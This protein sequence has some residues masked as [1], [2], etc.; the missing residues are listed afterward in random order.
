MALTL[1]TEPQ[2]EPV[3]LEEAKQQVLQ[4]LTVDDS[5]LGTILIP[6]AR[7][8]AELATGRALLTQTWDLVLDGFPCDSHIEI[9]K[10]PLQ[11]VTHLKYRDNV[12]TLQTWATSNYVVEAP[13]GPRCRRGRLSLAYGI[14]WPATYG[15]AGDVTVRFI[16]GYGDADDVPHLLKV[17]I[18][19]DVATLYAQRENAVIGTSTS[20]ALYGSSQIYWSFRSPATQK[21]AA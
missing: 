15:Q 18:L 16:C 14:V 8:R 1:I 5:Y 7:D 9:P 17:G 13:D 4:G 21:L 3:T 6:S 10:P 11:S 12:G 20:P 19:M 2:G